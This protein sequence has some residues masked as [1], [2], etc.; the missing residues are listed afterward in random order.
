M[1]GEIYKTELITTMVSTNLCWI[2]CVVAAKQ[3][4]L[5]CEKGNCMFAKHVSAKQVS[6]LFTMRKSLL[7]APV[8]LGQFCWQSWQKSG[9]AAL[10]VVVPLLRPDDDAGLSDSMS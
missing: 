6:S 4:N 3:T 1:V 9:V 2:R 5:E 10:S 7:I 8:W